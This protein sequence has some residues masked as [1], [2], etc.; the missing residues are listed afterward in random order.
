MLD[1]V[2]NGAA[3]LAAAGVV[4]AVVN[5]L[6]ALGCALY[7]P[8]RQCNEKRQLRL[9]VLTERS[10]EKV[11]ESRVKR[12]LMEQREHELIRQME[13]DDTLSIEDELK[14]EADARPKRVSTRATRRRARADQ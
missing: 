5:G 1:V 7:I 2:S 4:F 14:E 10:K 8:L 11:T 12:L 13:L 6:I 3:A 9:D